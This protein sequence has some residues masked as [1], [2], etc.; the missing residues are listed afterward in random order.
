MAA[1]YIHFEVKVDQASKRPDMPCG[2]VVVCDKNQNATTV[3]ICDGIG[4]GV[5]ANIF[6]TMCAAR[7]K[8][9]LKRGFSPLH[10]FFQ[11]CKYNERS[12]G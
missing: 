12:S 9:L 3:I 8:E 4:S 2:D 5:K 7:V 1:G 11:C 10:A 6:A